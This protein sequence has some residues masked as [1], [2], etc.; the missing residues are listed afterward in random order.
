MDC[1]R[2]LRWTTICSERSGSLCPGDAQRKGRCS[3]EQGPAQQ[4][5][6]ERALTPADQAAK[7]QILKGS[8]WQESMHKFDQW[9]SAQTIYDPQQVETIK[10]RL[11]LGVS[12]MT[13]SQLQR[14]QADID[15]KVAV[16]TSSQAQQASTYLAETFAVASPA[17]ARKIRAKLPD[18]LTMTA[19]QIT[20]QL[21]VFASKH[22]ATL[23]AQKTFEDD[24][25]Q[26]IAYN[27]AQL[28][29][30]RDESDKAIAR[31]SAGA[32]SG[33]KSGSYSAARDYFPNVG[34]DGPFGPGT[35]YGGFGGF[36]FF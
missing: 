26:S 15:E 16:L 1:N 20:Q 10:K 36:G 4:G 21:N 34:N 6:D 11:V 19:A 27:E 7:E 18:V 30:M 22:S 3:G 2:D 23:A 31:A 12:R 14:F 17:Y 32:A 5:P 24:R 29:A 8:A 33:G 28:A 25:Q 9:L 13:P 35:S